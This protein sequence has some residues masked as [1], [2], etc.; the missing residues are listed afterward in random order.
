MAVAKRVETPADPPV[1]PG[2]AAAV[3]VEERKAVEKKRASHVEVIARTAYSAIREFVESIG[4]DL[5]E[6]WNALPENGPNGREFWRDAAQYVLRSRHIAPN[7]AD[8]QDEFP[9]SGDARP[10]KHLTIEQRTRV[11]LFVAICKAFIELDTDR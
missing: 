11:Y 5:L 10:Y 8:L 1:A 7:P 3:A 2:S 9:V 4:E 6:E